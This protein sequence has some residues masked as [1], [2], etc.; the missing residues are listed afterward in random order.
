MSLKQKSVI[1]GRFVVLTCSL[2]VTFVPA[3]FVFITIDEEINTMTIPSII[4]PIS[5]ILDFILAAVCTFTALLALQP[6]AFIDVSV[7]VT[8]LSIS[9]CIILLPFTLKDGTI[10]ICQCSKA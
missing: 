8:H 10:V 5:N 3:S 6:I 9:I 4:L 1:H 2:H 7:C